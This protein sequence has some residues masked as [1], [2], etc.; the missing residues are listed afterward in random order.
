MNYQVFPDKNATDEEFETPSKTFAKIVS[1]DKERQMHL[2]QEKVPFFL[3]NKDR[4]VIKAHYEKEKKTGQE[5][6]PAKRAM[7]GT[8]ADLISK[9]DEEL[10]SYA[11]DWLVGGKKSIS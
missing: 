3:Q 1:E 11:L 6:W 9:A 7:H 8:E 4:K 5:I 2:K 10:H